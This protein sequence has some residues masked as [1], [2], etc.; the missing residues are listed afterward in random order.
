[1]VK[2]GGAFD[3][4][5]LRCERPGAIGAAG[6]R[7]GPLIG[8]NVGAES[9]TTGEYLKAVGCCMKRGEYWVGEYCTSGD[10]MK[11]SLY[12]E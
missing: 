11:R 9:D 6:A 7:D 2:L 4:N 1:M 10:V 12:S 5:D 3:D 8:W